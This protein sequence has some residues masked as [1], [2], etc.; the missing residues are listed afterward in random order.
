[1]DGHVPDEPTWTGK[2]M[3]D[4]AGLDTYGKGCNIQLTISLFG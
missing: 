2:I 3:Q 1:M 4:F